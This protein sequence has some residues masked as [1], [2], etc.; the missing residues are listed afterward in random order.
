MYSP[1]SETSIVLQ[2]VGCISTIS[3]QGAT[4]IRHWSAEP[5]A[6]RRNC[7]LLKHS[8]RSLP[9]DGVPSIIPFSTTVLPLLCPWAGYDPL[10]E[11]WGGKGVIRE[12]G[13]LQYRNALPSK[14]LVGK[15]SGVNGPG[16]S[17]GEEK[18]IIPSLGRQRPIGA[19]FGGVASFSC[20]CRL[21]GRGL[22][23][24]EVLAFSP[25]KWIRNPA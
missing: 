14:A 18:T 15:Q 6:G 17:G 5:R 7:L 23:S 21:E 16:R 4:C 1:P 22:F 25:Q 10:W 9:Q 24:L 2:L 3:L 8:H 13:T 20:L 19:G 12:A 11:E